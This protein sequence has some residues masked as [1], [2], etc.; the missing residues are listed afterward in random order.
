MIRSR[1]LATGLLSLFTVACSGESETVLS[2]I[3]NVQKPTSTKSDISVEFDNKMLSISPEL[4]NLAQGEKGEFK[5]VTQPNFLIDQVQG[6]GALLNKSKNKVQVMGNGKVCTIKVTSRV[7]SPPIAVTSST[8]GYGEFVALAQTVEQGS[9]FEIQV[10]PQQDY[11]LES[12]EGCGSEYDAG[13]WVVKN[14]QSPC[15]LLAKFKS[16]FDTPEAFTHTI[17]L[18]VVVHVL[19]NDNVQIEDSKIQRQIELLNLHFRQSKLLEDLENFSGRSKIPAAQIPFIADVGIQFYLATHTPSDRPFNGINRVADQGFISAASI[20]GSMYDSNKYINIWVGEK[21]PEQVDDA[22]AYL[23][24]TSEVA[25]GISIDYRALANY[26]RTFDPNLKKTLTHQF[27]HFLGLIGHITEGPESGHRFLPCGGD[28]QQ[29]LNCRNQDL[30]FNYMRNNSVDD[31][32]KRMFSI[33]QAEIMRNWVTSGPLK[34]LYHN[35]I[36]KQ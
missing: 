20:L 35:N 9:H 10:K 2:Q 17:R 6:C 28:T 12:I 4:L 24:G 5:I 18:P 23:A 34:Q 36:D 29:S 27:G 33:S 15:H 14:A 22:V 7:S 32:D 26:N 21:S 8:S 31:N 16:S 11:E 1:I 3:D 30:L 13:T 25:S 19:E